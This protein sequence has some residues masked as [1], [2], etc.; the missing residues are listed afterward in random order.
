MREAERRFVEFRQGEDGEEL[1]GT[2]INFGEIA[3]IGRFTERVNAGA[4]DGYDESRMV[5]N[6]QH[7]RRQP[8]ARP[9]TEYLDLTND[10]NSFGMRLRYPPTDYGRR[11]KELVDVGILR[12]LSV[13]M[14]V[15]D[16]GESWNARERTINRATLVGFGLVDIPAYGGSVLARSSLPTEVSGEFPLANHRALGVKGSFVWDAISVVSTQLRRAVRFAPGS[17]DIQTMPITLLAG[18]SFNDPLAATGAGS[19]DV[20]LTGRGLEWSAKRL[21]PTQKGKDT[22]ALFR[23]KL[24]TGFRI[25][26]VAEDEHVDQ[27]KVE[28]GGMEYDLETVRQGLLCDIRLTSDGTGGAGKVSRRAYS[29]LEGMI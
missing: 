27:S 15:P 9:D 17:L 13:E 11:A 1:S 6:I 25:G 23:N 21:A 10:S 20:K 3:T 5:M 29:Y 18:N 2:V 4:F 12:G 24:I 28:I 14:I 16:D 22:Q 8:L 19:L 26:Y 7:D